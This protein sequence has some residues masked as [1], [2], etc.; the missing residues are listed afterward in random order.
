MGKSLRIST[1]SSTYFLSS[2]Y[3]NTVAPLTMSTQQYRE[4]IA[5][6][7]KDELVNRHKITQRRCIAGG[8][9][10]VVGIAMAVTT[11]GMS[12]IRSTIGGVEQAWNAKE[13]KLFEER[14]RREGWA[15]HKLGLRDFALP[16]IATAVGLAI[17]AGMDGLMSDTGGPGG[18]DG[19]SF[20]EDTAS[21]DTSGMAEVPS[22]AGIDS[23]GPPEILSRRRIL[24]GK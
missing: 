18:S 12:L 19:P 23:L 1:L 21:S 10:F 15:G 22:V 9:S 17:G 24:L 16:V 2:D 3:V 8:I 5:H 11:E 20:T 14:L 4:E 13:A 7:S 6:L